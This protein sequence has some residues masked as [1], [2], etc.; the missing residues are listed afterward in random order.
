MDNTH[1]DNPY[2]TGEVITAWN[3]ETSGVTYPSVFQGGMT[4]SDGY[5]TVPETGIYYI[6]FTL[7]AQPAFVNQ[8]ISPYIAVDSLQIGLS[9][10]YPDNDHM[11]SH[12]LGQLWKVEKESRLS[13]VEGAARMRYFFA[14]DFGSFGAWKVD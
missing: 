13:V 4:Y 10:E 2:R 8:L 1:K 12:Y 9:Q 3:T 6:Y 7:Y 14:G 11:E 5:I